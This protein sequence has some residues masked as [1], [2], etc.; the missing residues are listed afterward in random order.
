[1]LV[2]KKIVSRPF[3]CSFSHQETA[4]TCRERCGGQG[5]LSCN[6]FG[7]LIGFA[8]AG[9]TAEGDNRVLLQKV[10]KELLGCVQLPKVQARVKVRS[11]LT[12][13]MCGL[14]DEWCVPASLLKYPYSAVNL[15]HEHVASV[16]AVATSTMA[17]GVSPSTRG[18]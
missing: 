14:S 7:S 8:H 11:P 17:G 6:R 18:N 9:M 3:V 15:Q 13:L 12:G 16:Q 5:Y 10:A 2:S 4:T 1:M